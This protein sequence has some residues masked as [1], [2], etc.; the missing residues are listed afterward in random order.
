MLIKTNYIIH[1]PEQQASESTVLLYCDIISAPTDIDDAVPTEN[2][3]L[4]FY[5][6]EDNSNTLNLSVF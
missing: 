6:H 3:N 2:A 5:L 4:Y 1:A